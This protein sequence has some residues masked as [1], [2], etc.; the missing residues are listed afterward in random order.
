MNPEKIKMLIENNRNKTIYIIISIDIPKEIVL[1]IINEDD[2]I[3][4]INRPCGLVIKNYTQDWGILAESINDVTI[5]I[6]NLLI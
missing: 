3:E 1:N 6:K 2:T 4:F 5:S